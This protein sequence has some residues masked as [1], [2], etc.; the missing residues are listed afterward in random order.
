MIF[1]MRT[2]IDTHVSMFQLTHGEIMHTV[3]DHFLI[4]IIF[5]NFLMKYLTLQILKYMHS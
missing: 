3:K 4:F 1:L 5:V 2:N